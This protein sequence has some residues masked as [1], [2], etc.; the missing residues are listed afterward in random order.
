MTLLNKLPFKLAVL[1]VVVFLYDAALAQPRAESRVESDYKKV[2]HFSG[3]SDPSI[4]GPLSPDGP[5]LIDKNRISDFYDLLLAPIASWIDRG[6]VSIRA[7]SRARFDWT[8]GA[9]WERKSNANA[10]IDI[11][12]AGNLP[13]SEI[14]SYEGGFP[15]GKADSLDRLED[16]EEKALKILWNV[17]STST[18]S[19]DAL[20]GVDVSWFTYSSRKRRASAL[21]YR[22]NGMPLDAGRQGEDPVL[23][24]EMFV[25]L[26]PPVVFGYSQILKRYLKEPADEI[27]AYSPVVGTGR[28]MFPANRGDGLI[29]SIISPDDFFVWSGKV[30][31]LQA[32]V[33]DSKRLLVPFSSLKMYGVDRE[34]VA[35]SSSNFVKPLS[36]RNLVF[37]SQIKTRFE[38]VETVRGNLTDQKGNEV[39]V[40]FNVD[41]RVDKTGASWMPTSLKFVPRD[42]WI[43]EVKSQNP[44]SVAGREIVVVDKISMLPIYKI[45][46]DQA[47][48]YLRTVVGSWAL[49]LGRGNTQFPLLTSLLVVD[50]RS[51]E[52]AVLETTY[53]RTFYGRRT[54][55]SNELHR[56][57]NPKTLE[58][59]I[60][61]EE[62][63]EPVQKAKKPLPANSESTAVSKPSS[64]SQSKKPLPA[65]EKVKRTLPKLPLNDLDF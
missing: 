45:V 24:Q 8:Y 29:G 18:V 58:K 37:D 4:P 62:K 43:I 17:I 46:Y 6:W 56:L 32:T 61:P 2:Q 23:G 35:I 3:I 50:G 34:R 31:A 28:K 55:A 30:Q 39:F 44:Y 5:I 38:E 1:S 21:I 11:D 7:T 60:S 42:T 22:Q 10:T 26:T 63:E 64:Q 9:D 33:L 51:R 57:M 53:A 13:F 36:L 47:G 25:L 19:G 16:P 15:F 14:D 48:E 49:A 40:K 59:L 65:R 27:W 54:E 41:T 12:T 52:A 20:Y